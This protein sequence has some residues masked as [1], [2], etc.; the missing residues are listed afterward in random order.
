MTHQPA[1]V[2]VF[3]VCLLFSRQFVFDSVYVLG[4]IIA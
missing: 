1:K 4:D 3:F 2:T